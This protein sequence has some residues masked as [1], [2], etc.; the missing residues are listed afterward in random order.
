ME[1][2]MIAGLAVVAIGG[3]YSVLDLLEDVGIRIKGPRKAGESTPSGRAVL[4]AQ[5]VVKKMAGMNV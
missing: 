1:A 4:S 3:Y 2:V 5:G